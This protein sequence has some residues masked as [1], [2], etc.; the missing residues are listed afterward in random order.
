MKI[1]LYSITYLGVWYKGGALSLKEFIK[2]T[3]E[4]GYSGIEIDGKRPHGNPMDLCAKDRQEI[5]AMTAGEGLDMVAIAGNNDFTSPV[6]ELR[7]AQIM[8]VKE[9]IKLAADL[10]APIVRL[11]VAWTGITMINGIA[12]YDIAG[13][14]K[15]E[16]L[17]HIPRIES[18]EYARDCFREVAKFAEDQGVTLALQDHHPI[19]RD[20]R[21]V[22]DMIHQVNSPAFK[23]CLD[24]PLFPRQDDAWVREACQAAGDLQI[25]THYNG[26]FERDANG[27]VYE[28]MIPMYNRELVNTAGFVRE[29]KAI[30]YKGYHCYEFCHE[31]L[32]KGFVTQGR[33]YVDAQAALALEFLKDIM[34]AEGCY[35]A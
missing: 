20:H 1:G 25:H 9:Q 21:D 12:H 14:I 17:A 13:K 6:P 3:K 28:R 29:L 10:G 34:V 22:L 18:W 2:K 8:M 32:G 33:E 19:I 27:K 26:E 15:R 35:E 24:V 7:E 5:K 31:A 4:L 23:A 30:G 11:F 16:A